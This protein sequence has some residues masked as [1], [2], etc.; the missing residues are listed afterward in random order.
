VPDARWVLQLDTA[1]LAGAQGADVGLLQRS[2]LATKPVVAWSAASPYALATLVA[3]GDG[4]FV[5][6]LEEDARWSDGELVTPQQLEL[7]LQWALPRLGALQQLYELRFA[8]TTNNGV[9]L[10]SAL[11]ERCVHYVLRHLD[12]SPR[13]SNAQ[14]GPYRF[15]QPLVASHT[16]T[17]RPLRLMVESD[18]ERAEQAYRAGRI[19]HTCPTAFDLAARV[20]DQDAFTEARPD[21][22]AAMG[23]NPQRCSA[24]L[25]EK[26]RPGLLTALGLGL[27]LESERTR[28]I[29]PL[30]APSSA[31]P[32]SPLPY[33]QLE[34][35]CSN[36]WPNVSIA[37]AI[38]H[39]LAERFGI[40]VIVTPCSLPRLTRRVKQGDY[41]L[42]LMLKQGLGDL[43]LHAFFL[44]LCSLAPLLKPEGFGALQRALR[45]NGRVCWRLL[46]SMSS[47]FPL[48]SF[49]S[50]YLSSSKPQTALG[51]GS[52]ITPP[53]LAETLSAA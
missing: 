33:D 5:L 3:E 45:S 44:A 15:H 40:P 13:R 41:Q 32:S 22:V 1:P 47:V 14:T 11:P 18:A 50:G 38:G 37:N 30:I 53:A 48:C 19:T 17:Q 26:H 6:Q 52:V 24:L 27:Q 35:I 36:F 9:R 10:Q 34:L 8:G 23:V 21:V 28:S 12:F 16:E 31:A 39:A 46:S 49:S 51:L 7:S 4:H 25:A 43:D 42:A 20:R 29:I 2:I